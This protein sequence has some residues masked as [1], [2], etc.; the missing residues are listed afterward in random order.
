MAREYYKDLF[1]SNYNLDY[2]DQPL[3]IKTH[4]KSP[5]RFIKIPVQ[6]KQKHR[7]IVAQYCDGKLDWPIL[8]DFRI[9]C[10]R[11]PIRAKQLNKIRRRRWR[12]EH[13]NNQ[14]QLHLK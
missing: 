3:R 14:I 10:D 4:S 13:E 7:V 6:L 5:K 12:S 1:F 11:C 9:P 8:I 2:I